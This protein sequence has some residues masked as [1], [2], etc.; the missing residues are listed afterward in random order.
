MAQSIAD[1]RDQ[2]F[3]L[4]EMLSASDLA[5]HELFEDFTKRPW[6]WWFPKLGIWPLKNY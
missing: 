5:E 4:H 6:T 3:V 2:D 1:R